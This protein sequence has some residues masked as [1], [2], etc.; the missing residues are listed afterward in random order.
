MGV[1][2]TNKLRDLMRKGVPTVGTHIASTWTGVMEAIGHS[3]TMDYAEFTSIS[4]PYDLYALDNLAIASSLFDMSTMIKI[5]PEPKHYLAQRAIGAGIQ[6]ILFS[7]LRTIADVEQAIRAVRAEPVGWNGASFN[8]LEGYVLGSGSKDFVKYTS[9]VVVAI[10]VEKMSLYE[11]IEDLMNFDG[12]DMIQ[13]GGTDFSLSLGTPG[14]Y[15]NPKLVEAEE[16][17]IKLALKHDKHPRGELFAGPTGTEG[18][19]KRLQRFIDLGVR[20]FCIGSDLGIIFYWLK[21]YGALTRK[22]LN[23]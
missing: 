23:L 12:V 17:T 21:E 2:R 15:S 10:M 3:G 11:K 4:A 7:D 1:L 22:A 13:F 20:D 19:I 14:D 5:D 16:R 18:F 9:D 8:R 6:N